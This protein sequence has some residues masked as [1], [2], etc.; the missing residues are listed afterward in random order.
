MPVGARGRP[1]CVGSFF[2]VSERLIAFSSACSGVTSLLTAATQAVMR[3]GSD[4][5]R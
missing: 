5:P 2:V 3:T 4:R 1:A